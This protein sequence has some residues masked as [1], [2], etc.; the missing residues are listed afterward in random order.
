VTKAVTHSNIHPSESA[1]YNKAT[2]EA[3]M[4]KRES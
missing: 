2:A 4:K 3:E 1:D